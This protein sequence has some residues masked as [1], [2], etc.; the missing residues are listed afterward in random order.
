M[1]R[2]RSTKFT[3]AVLLSGVAV[4][5]LTGCGGGG[6]GDADKPK[7]D[8]DVASFKGDSSKMPPEIREQ[9]LKSQ[10]QAQGKPANVPNK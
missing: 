5:A 9:M 2:T 6:G 1:K 4:A 8:A 3:S 7:T 10:Q